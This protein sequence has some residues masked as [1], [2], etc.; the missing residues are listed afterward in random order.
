MAEAARSRLPRVR[1]STAF[2]VTLASAPRACGVDARGAYG[3]GVAASSHAYFG[4]PRT[5]RD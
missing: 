4:L 3:S 1:V 5:L 2:D